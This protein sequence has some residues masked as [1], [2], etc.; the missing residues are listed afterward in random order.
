MPRSYGGGRGGDDGRRLQA[1]HD[2]PQLIEPQSPITPSVEQTKK[3]RSRDEHQRAR[4]LRHELDPQNPNRPRVAAPRRTPTGKFPLDKLRSNQ[5][6]GSQSHGCAVV[7]AGA[8]KQ[9]GEWTRGRRDRHHSRR[10][11]QT[12]RCHIHSRR[13]PHDR[14]IFHINGRK[15]SRLFRVECRYGVAYRLNA[16]SATDRD[17]ISEYATGKAGKEADSSDEH[18]PTRGL[19]HELDPQNPNRPV[20]RSQCASRLGWAKERSAIAERD[21]GADGTRTRN[22]RRDRP[23]L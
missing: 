19:W 15:G 20:C 1:Q 10:P 8:P 21:G 16:T 22:F 2:T 17:A 6:D 14:P 5:L 13:L 3:R 11:R 18:Q 23:V 4:G 7:V 12:P 9:S